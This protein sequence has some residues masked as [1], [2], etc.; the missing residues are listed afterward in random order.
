ME[1]WQ[2]KRDSGKITALYYTSIQGN[3]SRS[4]YAGVFCLNESK[5]LVNTIALGAIYMILICDLCRIVS[6]YKKYDQ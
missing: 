1:I 2:K 6:L 3:F 4:C 5:S